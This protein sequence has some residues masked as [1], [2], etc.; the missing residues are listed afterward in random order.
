[1]AHQVKV[2]AAELN[3]LSSYLGTHMGEGK[4][5]SY[6]LKAVS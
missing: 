5:D 6:E 1:M 3:D 4:I 2:L